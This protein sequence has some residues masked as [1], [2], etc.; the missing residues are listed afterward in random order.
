MG[1]LWV[2]ALDTTIKLPV[3]N[4]PSANTC[5]YGDIEKARFSYACAP[6]C[7][8]QRAGISIVFQRYRHM[9]LAL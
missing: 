7:L 5:A 6:A 3:Q 8:S 1:E 9:E 4:D 2:R